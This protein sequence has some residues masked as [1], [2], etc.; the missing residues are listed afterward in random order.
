MAV[1][2][3][4][5]VRPRSV[6]A[7][8]VA[9]WALAQLGLPALLESLRVNAALRD[10]ALGSVVARMAFSASERATHRWLRERRAV[11]ELLGV[12]FETV[13]AMQLY[14][15]SDALMAH[16]EAIEAHLFDAAMEL[17]DTR[18]T[19]TVIACQAV[20]VVRKLVAAAS[21]RPS[22]TTL[23]NILGGQQRV[24]ATFRRADGR[25]LHVRTATAVEPGQKAIY[26]ALGVDPDPGGTRKTVV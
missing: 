21:E 3:P 11:G 16:R 14:R 20:Q 23:R 8:H 7:E 19:V 26:D 15:A 12:D 4:A 5:L 2:S 18:P 9:L 13:G 6:G 17:F 1:D 25:T 22:L 24:T 10:A